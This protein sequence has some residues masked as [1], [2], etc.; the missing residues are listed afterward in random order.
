MKFTGILNGSP[1][2]SDEHIEGVKDEDLDIALGR[3]LGRM[4][5]SAA[6]ASN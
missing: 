4:L 3:F 6:D 5:D 2:Q 1:V